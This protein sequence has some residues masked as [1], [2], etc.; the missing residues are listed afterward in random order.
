MRKEQDEMQPEDYNGIYA[1]LLPLLGEKLV[2][3]IFYYYRGQQVIFPDQLYS[4]EYIQRYLEMNY[5]E[6]IIVNC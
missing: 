2:Q 3:R 4:P 6:K 5:N 1:E